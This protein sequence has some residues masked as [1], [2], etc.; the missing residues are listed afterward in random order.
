MEREVKIEKI[1]EEK[2]FRLYRNGILIKAVGFIPLT[3]TAPIKIEKYH[4]I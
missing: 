4:K 2:G 3:N 1:K